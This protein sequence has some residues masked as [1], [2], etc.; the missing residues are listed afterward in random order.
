MTRPV[1]DAELLVSKPNST[2]DL[3][4]FIVPA[5]DIISLSVDERAGA[6]VAKGSI[7]LDAAFGQW[8]YDPGGP[9]VDEGWGDS[10]GRMPWGGSI[11]VDGNVIAED[12]KIVI[13]TATT[14]SSGSGGFGGEPFGGTPFGGPAWSVLGT[15]IVTD[16]S[17]QGD[18]EGT[19]TMSIDV[20]NYV[21]NR[22][23]QR[24]VNEFGAETRPLSGAE[25]AVLNEVL[26]EHVPD[27][28]RSKLPDIAQTIDFWVDKKTANKVVDKLARIAHV[29]TGGPWILGSDGMGLT[30]TPLSETDPLWTA[31][32]GQIDLEGPFSSSRS[33]DEWINEI[34]VEGG[35]DSD[36]VDE[37]SLAGGTWVELTESNRLVTQ[38]SPAKPEIGK[39]DLL[40]R[41]V[42]ESDDGVQVRIHPDDGNGNPRD[43]ENSDLDLVSERE[44]FPD[45]FEG[46]LTLR[47]GEH[48]LGP[49]DTPHLV[50]E[51]TDD[52]GVEVESDGNG[53]PRFQT[54][55]PKPIIIRLPSLNS[56]ADYR[57]H[58]GTVNDDSLQSF[59]AARNRGDVELSQH[60]YPTEEYEQNAASD[61]AHDL[62]I[63]DVIT[64]DYPPR[65]ATG[66]Y[67]VTGVAHSYSGNLQTTDLTLRSLAQFV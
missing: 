37:E 41:H 10:W 5:A 55:F 56:Q 23:K 13:R 11:R 31:D 47:P 29:E 3:A 21:F 19:Q 28:D 57:I 6:E 12:D 59:A 2:A 14:G 24:T 44:D 22:L 50:V 35:I 4:D 39:I 64:L 49:Q 32:D 52:D 7:E 36:N 60:A 67:V 40:V 45:D 18:I 26:R 1:T 53:T 54:F 38:L 58:D 16:T 46:R 51:G 48:I 63:G 43:L 9:I 65:R 34:R 66:D 30:L 61:R 62:D 17:V 25:D 8:A 33:T 15:V 27:I 42:N 20:E